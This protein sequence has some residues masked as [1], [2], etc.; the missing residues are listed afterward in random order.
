MEETAARP[1]NKNEELAVVFSRRVDF[2]RQIVFPRTFRQ[3]SA[4]VRGALS[5]RRVGRAFVETALSL[6]EVGAAGAE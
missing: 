5:S 3:A 4:F 2:G 6:R 1:Y